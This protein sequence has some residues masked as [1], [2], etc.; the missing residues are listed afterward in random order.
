[1]SE[2]RNLNHIIKASK[3]ESNYITEKKAF[4]LKVIVPFILN[5]TS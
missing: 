5:L 4:K 3:I 1:M 2:Y